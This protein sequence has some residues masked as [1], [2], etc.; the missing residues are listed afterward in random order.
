M[1]L[2]QLPSRQLSCLAIALG[3]MIGTAFAQPAPVTVEEVRLEAL[4]ST[5][6]VTGNLRSVQR[7]GVA[8]QEAGLVVAV[9]VDVGSVVAEG[10]VIARL[11]DRRMKAEQ[12]ALAAEREVAQARLGEAKANAEF[13]TADFQRVENLRTGGAAAEIELIRVKTSNDATQAGITA[14]EQTIERIKA[15]ETLVEIRLSDMEITAPFAGVI[16]ERTVDPGEWLSA[17][18][19]VVTIVSTGVHEAWLE[20]PERY[21]DDVTAASDRLQVHLAAT[22]EALEARRF[23]LSPEVDP[24]VRTFMA[25]VDVQ[26]SATNLVTGM[27]VTAWAPTSVVE[28]R[29]TIHKDALI[30]DPSGFLV[31]VVRERGED[32]VATPM[33]VKVAF[34]TD[35]RVA[36]FPGALRVGDLVVIEG[37]ERLYAGAPIMVNNPT[38]AQEAAPAEAAVTQ[39]NDVEA[40]GG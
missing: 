26:S 31:F 7:A 35:T 9:L 17:G 32:R 36:L 40:R 21:V 28:E 33:P 11:D 22:D 3:L 1:P 13:A 37:N 27:S 2:I 14:A 16:T 39:E 8:T 23:R 19:P 12:A 24:R 15:R 10:D 18:D 4:G 30:R 29:Q 20:I 34:E 25:I 38:A 6:R 5:A